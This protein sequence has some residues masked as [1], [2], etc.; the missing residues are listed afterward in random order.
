M[1]VL[2]LKTH[3]ESGEFPQALVNDAPI[4]MTEPRLVF[5][6]SAF[7]T[8]MILR[9]SAF[10]TG[11]IFIISAFITGVILRISVFTYTCASYKIR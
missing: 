8:G 11:V 4:L 1:I 9:I 6:I 3:I 5:I 2:V 10:I 7:I